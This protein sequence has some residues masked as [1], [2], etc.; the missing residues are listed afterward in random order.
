ML[1]RAKSRGARKKH[2]WTAGVRRSCKALITLACLCLAAG[3]FLGKAESR[4][5]CFSPE[6]V[7]EFAEKNY[8]SADYLAAAI[9]FKRFVHFFPD[10]SKASEAGFKAGMSYFQIPRYGDAINAFELV[11]KRF[12]ESQYAVDA[13]FMISRCH[14]GMNN[15]KEAIHTLDAVAVRA[16]D[17][18][19]RDRA[20]YNMG[21]LRLESGELA[22]AR[23]AFDKVSHESR[24][25]FHVDEILRD[26]DDSDRIPVK[27]PVIAGLFSI[28]PG[29]GYLYCGRYREAATAFFLTAGLAAA[30]WEAF[31][32]DLH[33]I[34]GLAALA[35]AGFYGGGA[36]G[37]VSS[38]HKYNR[39]SYRDYMRQ[40]SGS[41]GQSPFFLGISPDSVMVSFC[42]RF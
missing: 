24:D 18:K 36:L 15:I 6:A 30:S 41:S 22:R 19:D 25:E 9:E 32:N 21:R 33:A 12:A 17:Q 5:L 26:L 3:V 40:R 39:Q 23:A 37:A 35:G 14:A 1:P 31:D 11:A 34:G 27:S 2:S 38:A 42:W 13:M 8:K 10:H 7:Y 4:E 28:V 16:P 20:F 29:G